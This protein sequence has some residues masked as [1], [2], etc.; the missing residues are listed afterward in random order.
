MSTCMWRRCAEMRRLFFVTVWN[1]I[2]ELLGKNPQTPM[3]HAVQIMRKQRSTSLNLKFVDEYLSKRKSDFPD[4]GVHAVRGSDD[5]HSGAVS[6]HRPNLLPFLWEPTLRRLQRTNGI[7]QMWAPACCWD[8][9]ISFLREGWIYINIWNT[10][11]GFFILILV[12]S[13]RTSNN[14]SLAP[15]FGCSIYYWTWYSGFQSTLE[16]FVLYV[17]WYPQLILDKQT[18][19]PR[20]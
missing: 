9:S 13:I 4:G 12:D 20:G 8:F 6:W 3:R 19:T 10:A 7:F 14:T 11:V 5:R 2:L 17:E 1:K 18:E 15:N 16:I